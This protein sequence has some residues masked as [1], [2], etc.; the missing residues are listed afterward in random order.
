MTTRTPRT[1][2][3]VATAIYPL[4]SLAAAAAVVL[5]VSTPAQARDAAP[6]PGAAAVTPVVT[7]PR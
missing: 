2:M 7:A 4:V 6:P 3:S 5:S 1:W